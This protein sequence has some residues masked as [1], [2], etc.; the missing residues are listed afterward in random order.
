MLSPTWP[1]NHARIGMSERLSY[2][3]D[4]GVGS[5]SEGATKQ[6]SGIVIFASGTPVWFVL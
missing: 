1:Y 6:Q 5:I 3:L 2:N 4:V